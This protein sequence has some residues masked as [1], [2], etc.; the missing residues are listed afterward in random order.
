MEMKKYMSA[1]LL[2]GIMAVSCG[3]GFAEETATPAAP[4]G[5]TSSAPVT[6]APKTVAKK[7]RKLGHHKKGL[8]KSVSASQTPTA[9][10]T[11]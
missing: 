9:P 11:K 7:H 2:S 4:Q 10:E 8:K 6:P 1:A 5:Q 3:L